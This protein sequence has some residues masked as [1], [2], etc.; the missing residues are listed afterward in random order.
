MTIPDD[1]ARVTRERDEARQECERLRDD[2]ARL[3]AVV[4]A[5]RA[6]TDDVTAAATR[7]RGDA[8]TRLAMERYVD[9]LHAMIAA[10]RA[11][12]ATKGGE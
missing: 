10:V 12:D 4:E 3:R 1:L 5:A 7:S 2:N 6:L 8:D 9:L 11:L